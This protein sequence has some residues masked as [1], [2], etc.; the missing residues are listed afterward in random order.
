MDYDTWKVLLNSA[1]SADRSEAADVVP[2]GAES[3]QVVRDLANAL[4]DPVP[5]VRTC[6]ADT[7]GNFECDDARQALRAQLSAETDVLTRAYVLSSLAQIGQIRD[8]RLIIDALTSDAP[9]M[10]RA[11]AAYGL[12]ELAIEQGIAATANLCDDQDEAVRS[13]CFSHLDIIVEAMLHAL[14]HIKSLAEKHQG[15]DETGVAR[16]HIEHILSVLSGSA[17][18][19]PTAGQVE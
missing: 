8:L 16:S 19:L 13:K 2:E 9:G 7:L 4:G 6:A 11:H 18:R 12:L 1:E 3:A 17:V 10:I 5:L 14:R 15:M